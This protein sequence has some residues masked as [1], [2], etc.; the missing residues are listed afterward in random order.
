MLKNNIIVFVIF[1]YIIYT[2][3]IPRFIFNKYL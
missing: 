2:H 1:N 3:K